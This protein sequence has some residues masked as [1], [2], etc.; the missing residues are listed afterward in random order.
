[1]HVRV[2]QE[3]LG[4]TDIRITQRYAHASSAAVADAASRMGQA[5]WGATGQLQ[6]PMQ[7]KGRTGVGE[8]EHPAPGGAA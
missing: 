1:V 7:P 5:L 6:P 2:V 3:I 4:H 8:D